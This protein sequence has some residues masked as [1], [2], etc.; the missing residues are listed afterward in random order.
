MSR[1]WITQKFYQNSKYF[2]V[3]LTAS[4]PPILRN[5]FVLS[6]MSKCLHVQNA[7]MSDWLLIHSCLSLLC[8]L[9]EQS[10][11]FHFVEIHSSGVCVVLFISSFMFFRWYFCPDVRF[12]ISDSFFKIK[13]KF[14]LS[15]I[16]LG[17]FFTLREIYRDMF[18][19]L[20]VCF[21][22]CFNCWFLFIVLFRKMYNAYLFCFLCSFSTLWE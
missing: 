20:M 10:L 16:F 1:Y 14:C 22:V 18:V 19:R 15:L 2:E 8:F 6:N 4:S 13:K 21:Y 9:S 17:S 11:T 5:I 3:C 12:L 7:N